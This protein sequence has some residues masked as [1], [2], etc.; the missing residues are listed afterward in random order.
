ME[1]FGVHVNHSVQQNE[2][3][4]SMG[5]SHSVSQ[6]DR[7]PLGRIR[8]ETESQDSPSSISVL[9]HKDACGRMVKTPNTLLN[10][11]DTLPKRV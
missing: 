2:M 9:P 6:P 8:T 11:V 10:L 1:L 5:V 4:E 3:L 7:K